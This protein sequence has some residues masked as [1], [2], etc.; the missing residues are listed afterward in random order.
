MDRSPGTLEDPNPDTGQPAAGTRK[1]R[2]GL[3]GDE[4]PPEEDR[5]LT[6]PNVITLIRFLCIPLFVWLLFGRDDHFLA[7]LL[8]GVM[9]GTDWVDGYIARHFNQ[10]S[11]IGKML[12][13]AVDRLLMIVGIGGT[14]LV[15]LDVPYFLVFAAI[16]IVREVTLS[17]FV[18]T[19]VLLGA[20]RM[21]VSRIG[22]RSMAAM[23][24]AFP[25]FLA[26][27]DSR[28][29]GTGTRTAFL[30]LA[31]VAAVP[32]V[33]LGLIAYVGYLRG[34][35]VALRE[36]RAAHAAEVAADERVHD[37]TG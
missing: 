18:S 23:L 26:A 8:L 10:I 1:G 36:G 13:P 35:L 5:I 34:G 28:F 25:A 4:I 27:S 21:D 22:K 32:G 24:V 6:V 16:V 15:G 17:I 2:R 12:D 20:K 30:V 33:V 19:T 14:V 29:S 37:A 7:A 31:W 3:G 9:G 11:Y